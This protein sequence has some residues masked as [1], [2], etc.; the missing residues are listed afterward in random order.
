LED[1]ALGRRSS[2]RT[3]MSGPHLRI[4]LLERR[5]RR[6][7]A[8][9]QNQ[10]RELVEYLRRYALR[11]AE[12]DLLALTRLAVDTTDAGDRIAGY[13]SLAATSVDRTLLASVSA[14]ARL[15]QFPVPAILLAR[16]A[17]DER[18]QG[19]G[20][21][22]YLFEDALARSLDIAR[23]IGTRLLVTDAIDADAIAFYEHLGFESLSERGFPRR[24]VLDL[25]P[26]L[27]DRAIG[28]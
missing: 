24:M 5:H 15:P 23:H 17:V 22:R 9:F 12:T 6:L 16:L 14:L 3:R 18:A 2:A 13:H 7:L 26:F 11:H 4:E 10:H 19:Q 27:R 28:S 8:S 20:V 21:G 1:F 25:R